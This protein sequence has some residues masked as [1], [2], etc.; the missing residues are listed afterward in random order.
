MYICT[1]VCIHWRNSS[2]RVSLTGYDVIDWKAS[3]GSLWCM[4]K[5]IDGANNFKPH[6]I[7]LSAVYV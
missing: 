3:T 5:C 4:K 6:P 1:C 2:L 7:S